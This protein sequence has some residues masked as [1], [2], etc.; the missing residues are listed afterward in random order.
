MSRAKDLTGQTFADGS[1]VVLRRAE[2]GKTRNSR[3]L[4][5]CK[6]GNTFVEYGLNLKN[7]NRQSCGCQRKGGLAGEPM[8]DE[9]MKHPSTTLYM[10]YIGYVSSKDGDRRKLYV[11]DV[12]PLHRKKDGKQ[13]GYS[14]FTKSIGS[15]KESRFT[16]YN[17]VF[18]RDPI[19]EGDIIYCRGFERDGQYFT[20]TSYS[21]VI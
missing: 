18:D 4:C 17:R 16:V 11:T 6:C 12:R 8:T 13:F 15:G 10:G 2:N 20:L 21:K 9:Q 14:V 7:G 3:W 1:I 5:Q 19:N